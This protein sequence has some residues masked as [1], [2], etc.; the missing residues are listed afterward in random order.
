MSDTRVTEVER[1]VDRE[2]K[3]VFYKLSGQPLDSSDTLERD[4]L[5]KTER[6]KRGKWVSTLLFAP[7]NMRVILWVRSINETCCLQ[8]VPEMFPGFEKKIKMQVIDAAPK[9]RA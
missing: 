3:H 9:G 4:G 7:D 6:D 1:F 8:G 5:I 2:G